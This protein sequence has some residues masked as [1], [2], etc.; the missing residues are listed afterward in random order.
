MNR[1]LCLVR[2]YMSTLTFSAATLV[3]A[4]RTPVDRDAGFALTS[5]GLPCGSLFWE[6]TELLVELLVDEAQLLVDEVAR[7]SADKGEETLLVC[8]APHVPNG[9]MTGGNAVFPLLNAEAQPVLPA[10]EETVEAERLALNEDGTELTTLLASSEPPV[11]RAEVGAI[12]LQLLVEG[13][14]LQLLADNNKAEPQALVTRAEDAQIGDKLPT[15][16][17]ESGTLL[18]GAAKTRGSGRV[19]STGDT[20]FAVTLTLEEDR[21]LLVC[22]DV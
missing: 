7:A 2:G 4:V 18:A 5:A 22:G 16:T 6:C 20:E 19:T 12:M 14:E 10:D 9:E 8:E 1:P 13:T 17:V 3:E 15:E 21:E 11:P